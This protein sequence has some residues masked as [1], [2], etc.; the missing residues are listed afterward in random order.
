MQL[1]LLF[2]LTSLLFSFC[3][4]TLEKN[5]FNCKF[6]KS[7]SSE[8][9][10]IY[11]V[12]DLNNGILH[13]VSFVGEPTFLIYRT[14]LGVNS[15]NYTWNNAT[16]VGIRNVNLSNFDLLYGFVARSIIEFNVT[17]ASV[18]FNL[19]EFYKNNSSSFKTTLLSNLHY[20]LTNNT[21]CNKTGRVRV[22]LMQKNISSKATQLNLIFDLKAFSQQGRLYD[23]PRYSYRGNNSV[24]DF[25]ISNFQYNLT[26]ATMPASRL[27]IELDFFRYQS[28]QLIFSSQA[29]ID[30]EYT[31]AVFIQNTISNE[32]QG[33]YFY[34]KPIA[35]V[36]GIKTVENSMMV[37]YLNGTLSNVTMLP[38]TTGFYHSL[39]N[40]INVSLERAFFLFGT[41]GDSTLNSDCVVF[42]A[43]LGIGTPPTDSISLP[44]LVAIGIGF[45]LPVLG[46]ALG[47]VGMFCIMVYKC[48]FRKSTTNARY[49]SI[50]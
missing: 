2:I 36:S 9:Q 47:F 12:Y 43:E 19:T 50:N 25:T 24:I 17:S 7:P 27:A 15:L 34:W 35:Y 39:Q 22:S 33:N 11:T 10:G 31:P 45:G 48:C 38:N 23:Q 41:D 26:N 40:N 13:L 42:R 49:V 46:L 20:N 5:N 14:N 30:D 18:N 8:N 6:V 16:D 32:F 3:L 1:Q 29:N 37:T 4:S 21:D 28:E 44:L